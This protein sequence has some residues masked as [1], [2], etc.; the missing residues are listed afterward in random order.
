M[1]LIITQPDSLWF[2]NDQRKKIANAIFNFLIFSHVSSP[3][4]VRT[5]DLNGV[6]LSGDYYSM[7]TTL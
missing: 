3:T 7:V 1:P 4:F 5:A 2:P 6:N